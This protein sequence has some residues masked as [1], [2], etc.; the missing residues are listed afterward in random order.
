MYNRLSSEFMYNRLSRWME[1]IFQMAI[2]SIYVSFNGFA[3]LPQLV[4]QRYS[5]GSHS[6]RTIPIQNASCVTFHQSYAVT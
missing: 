6:S 3:Q 5:H 2:S 4:F 1:T